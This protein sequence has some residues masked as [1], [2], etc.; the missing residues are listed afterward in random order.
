MEKQSIT[1]KGI[2]I[3]FNV[4]RV[5]TELG[6]KSL[7]DMEGQ[8]GKPLNF[9]AMTDYPVEEEIKLIEIIGKMI[10]PELK[11]V[12]R[13]KK[14]GED[15]ANIFITSQIGRVGLSLFFPN[16]ENGIKNAS[17]LFG[18]L[19]QGMICKPIINKDIIALNIENNP[20][21]PNYYVGFFEKVLQSRN[22][23]KKI[24]VSSIGQNCIYTVVS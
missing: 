2:F 11:S 13:W 1:V 21:H 9:S 5:K 12:E 19:H 18:L 14:M 24:K 7:R 22:I 4:D 8:Y 23:N 20:Y 16:I 3:K 10:Y 15:D 17:R 6:E